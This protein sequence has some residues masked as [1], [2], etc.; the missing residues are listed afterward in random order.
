MLKGISTS[1]TFNRFVNT[2]AKST[3]RH[4]IRPP[5]LPKSSLTR[6]RMTKTGYTQGTLLSSVNFEKEILKLARA[7]NVSWYEYIEQPL[8]GNRE[9]CMREILEDI[10]FYSGFE[11]LERLEK[12][13]W[14][15]LKRDVVKYDS[16]VGPGCENGIDMP[17]SISKA[18]EN[19]RGDAGALV[20]IYDIFIQMVIKAAGSREDR[21]WGDDLSLESGLNKYD[22]LMN[23]G[24]E[25]LAMKL[26]KK[27]VVMEI[28]EGWKQ[29]E[30]PRMIK[31]DVNIYNRMLK[32]SDDFSS[33]F[34]NL[35]LKDLIDCGIGIEPIEFEIVLNNLK[36]SDN[37]NYEMYLKLREDLDKLGVSVTPKAYEMLLEC[38]YKNLIKDYVKEGYSI[39]NSM[40]RVLIKKYAE[41]GDLDRMIKIIKYSMKEM[42]NPWF[43]E[44]WENVL[45]SFVKAGYRSGAVDI[46]KSLVIIRE[47]WKE[48]IGEEDAGD[49][50][51]CYLL[52]DA[53]VLVNSVCKNGKLIESVP[54]W[55]EGHLSLLITSDKKSEFEELIKILGAPSSAEEVKV[56]L[57]MKEKFGYF[58]DGSGWGGFEKFQECIAEA[59]NS[60]PLEE[61][62]SL[63]LDRESIGIICGI[64]EKCGQIEGAE[65]EW[66]ELLVLSESRDEDMEKR[67]KAVV[68]GVDVNEGVVRNR[69]NDVRVKLRESE[70]V[71]GTL[72]NVLSVAK[73]SV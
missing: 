23:E 63:V 72:G 30:E 62:D 42:K 65:K 8:I 34:L 39:D 70:V 37:L 48:E 69:V 47:G 58:D 38:D 36:K 2:A 9:S 67:I 14:E 51:Y 5:T 12:N 43:E 7:N 61:I 16:I 56:R 45:Q 55:K 24:V 26:V 66:G 31:L 17:K 33:E 19:C 4:V 49:E 60:L 10:L 18:I 20:R 71:S 6:S 29:L 21:I 28:E 13:K 68:E 25:D 50:D 3:R 73:L 27:E 53:D 41:M 64:V 54:G 11:S 46:L 35:F 44:D 32:M 57:L 52:Q 1:R 15:L 40:V 59:M 22:A